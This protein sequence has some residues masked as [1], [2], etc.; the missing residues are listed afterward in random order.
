MVQR[1]DKKAPRCP[2]CRERLMNVAPRPKGVW[3]A[4]PCECVL[5]VGQAQKVI[6]AMG[7]RA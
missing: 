3:V 4:V 5:D 7:V 6:D 1:T 2:V